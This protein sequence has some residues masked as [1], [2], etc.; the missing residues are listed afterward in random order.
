MEKDKLFA[1]TLPRVGDFKF[2]E[3]VATV[4]AD[5]IERSVPGYQTLIELTGSIA[6]KYAQPD[7]NIYDLGCALGAS[8]NA[9]FTAIN[10]QSIQ[11]IGVDNSAAM[12]A[13]CEKILQPII[14][15]HQFQLIEENIEDVK[16]EN[17]CIVVMNF[18][19]QFI[20]PA[21]RDQLVARIYQGLV[22]NGVVIISEKIAFGNAQESAMQQQLHEQFKIS[23][24]YSEL[25]ISQKRIAL[26]KVMILDERERHLHRLRQA[27]FKNAVQW[28]QSF[29][30]AAF[31]GV[32]EN[33]SRDGVQ[34][35]NSRD[36][37]K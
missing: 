31:V 22:A 28:F 23:N 24:G 32:K 21:M 16:I 11:Y 10:H 18:T 34:D 36:G 27:G 25:E 20:E 26:E 35:N 5:M 7:T 6:K 4:F 30:F 8:M 2:D 37:V 15:R 12:L 13:K 19:L 33:N 9:M 3:S 17:A 29:N 14:P 1:Q